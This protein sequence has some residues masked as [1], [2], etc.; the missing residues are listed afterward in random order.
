MVKENYMVPVKEWYF[1]DYFAE[2]YLG[3]F[4]ITEKVKLSSEIY[5]SLQDGTLTLSQVKADIIVLETWA[6][7]ANHQESSIQIIPDQSLRVC[8]DN[9]TGNGYNRSILNKL[10]ELK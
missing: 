9:S 1:A 4:S 5:Q 6:K 8:L 3:D 7:F 2:L 10:K